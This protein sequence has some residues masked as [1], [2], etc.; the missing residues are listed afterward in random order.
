MKVRVVH[1]SKL[2]SRG[3]EILYE[4]DARADCQLRPII[5]DDSGRPDEPEP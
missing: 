2:K 3:V 4:K 1:I 5:P